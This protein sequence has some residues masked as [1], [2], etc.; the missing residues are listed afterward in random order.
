[1]SKALS[2][3]KG[4]LR[5]NNLSTETEK[6]EQKGLMFLCMGLVAAVQSKWS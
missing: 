1:M 3:D 6:D 5:I 4:S 2:P